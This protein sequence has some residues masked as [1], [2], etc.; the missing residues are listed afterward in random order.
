MRSSGTRP[1]FT[2]RDPAFPRTCPGSAG[3]RPKAATRRG[4][5]TARS[6]PCA[7]RNPRPPPAR[8]RRAG[9]GPH[10]AAA[11]ARWAPCSARQ[12]PPPASLPH[13]Q[14]TRSDSLPGAVVQPSRGPPGVVVRPPRG[15]PPR[16]PPPQGL[17][18]PGGRARRVKG[19][20]ASG[21][22]QEA[23]ALGRGTGRRAG[24]AALQ[25]LFS[26]TPCRHGRPNIFIVFVTLCNCAS[27]ASCVGMDGSPFFLVCSRFEIA[28]LTE[29]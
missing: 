16:G 22:A 6:G 5:T 19:T 2:T 4:G 24:V 14:S 20:A 27:R 9:S 7:G 29:R 12:P 26:S 1:T 10:T 15:P 17:Q 25:V 3:P 21:G 13:R 28:V 11:H 23:V 18:F 8:G